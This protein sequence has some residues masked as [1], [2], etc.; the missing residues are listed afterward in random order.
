MNCFPKRIISSKW[1][2]VLWPPIF[3]CY[4]S[5]FNSKLYSSFWYCA[6]SGLLLIMLR[7]SNLFPIFLLFLIIYFFY[8]QPGSEASQAFCRSIEKYWLPVSI[9]IMC[10]C[11]VWPQRLRAGEAQT[12]WDASWRT[13][14]LAPPTVN[15]CFQVLEMPLT[16]ETVFI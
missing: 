7:V 4:F 2:F 13:W 8:V 15:Q 9:S 6:L 10:V 11:D 5:W 3:S 1:A 16:E 14:P 12:S